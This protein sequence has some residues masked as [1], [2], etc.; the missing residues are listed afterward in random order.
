MDRKSRARRTRCRGPEARLSLIAMPWHSTPWHSTSD[1]RIRGFGGRSFPDRACHGI[2]GHTEDPEE[3]VRHGPNRSRN[4]EPPMSVRVEDRSPLRMSLLVPDVSLVPSMI[5]LVRRPQR[6][7]RHP[8]QGFLDRPHVPGRES[9]VHRECAQV[10]DSVSFDAT[11]EIDERIDVREDQIPDRAEDRFASVQSWVPRSCH[12]AVLG[13]AAEQ[14]DDMI[15]VILGFHVGE[16]RRIS[17]LLED[18]RGAQCALQAM[19]LVRPDDAAKGVEGFPMLFTIVGQRLEPPLHLFRRISGFDDRSFSRGEHR[20][21]RGGARTMFQALG[22]FLD[23]VLV[24]IPVRGFAVHGRALAAHR[25]SNR[26][27]L[28][29]ATDTA[30]AT[31]NKTMIDNPIVSKFKPA[32]ESPK[33]PVNWSWAPTKVRISMPPTPNATTTET[34]V[35]VRL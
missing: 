21:G 13:A 8:D 7:V 35:T 25:S 27:Y 32:S 29:D 18:R 9:P 2:T 12:G 3:I 24:P 20:P 4:L 15:E 28:Q 14:K 30:Q 11:R 17:V 6:A 26:L 1:P 10:E 22:A 5:P 16:D 34:I 33:G 23:F 31:T 19:H